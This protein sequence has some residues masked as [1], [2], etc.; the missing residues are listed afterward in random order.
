[1]ISAVPEL[2]ICLAGHMLYHNWVE[3]SHCGQL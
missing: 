1:M 2:A 3:T